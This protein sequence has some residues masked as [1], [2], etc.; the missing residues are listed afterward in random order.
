MLSEKEESSVD[1]LPSCSG[2]V[3]RVGGA[4]DFHWLQLPC[5]F[6]PFHLNRR[7]QR[8]RMENTVDVMGG[9]TLKIKERK[10]NPALYILSASFGFYW[11]Q[12][13]YTVLFD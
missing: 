5:I 12:S 9:P 13:V 1:V 6:L 4:L 7:A 3:A 10:K 8:K 11:A 2:G